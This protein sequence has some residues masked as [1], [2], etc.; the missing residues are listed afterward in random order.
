MCTPTGGS[1]PFGDYVYAKYT[2][3][4]HEI[5]EIYTK[6]EKYT[7]RSS[8]NIYDFIEYAKYV[9]IYEDCACRGSA[10]L[11]DYIYAKYTRNTRN[12]HEI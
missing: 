7:R 12:I 1:A 5:R 11:G 6:Y 3:N 9:N 8:Q 4:I 2:R 10:P